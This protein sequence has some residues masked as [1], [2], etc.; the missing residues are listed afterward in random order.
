MLRIG[1]CIIFVTRYCI[2]VLGQT[3]R[4]DPRLRLIGFFNIDI[5]TTANSYRNYK[6]RNPL[7]FMH[8]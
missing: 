5:A 2:P 6:N 7:H 3:S 1:I 8:L 4:I